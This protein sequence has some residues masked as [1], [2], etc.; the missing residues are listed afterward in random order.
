MPRL[1]WRLKRLFKAGIILAASL[2]CIIVFGAPSPTPLPSVLVDLQGA[3]TGPVVAGVD[4]FTLLTQTFVSFGG[5]SWAMRVSAVT[6]LAV[7]TMKVTKLDDLLWSKLRGLQAFLAPLLSLAGGVTVLA[8]QGTLSWQA[9]WLYL[10]AGAGAVALHELL[11]A[12]KSIPG[13]GSGYVMVIS[14]VERALG[15]NPKPNPSPSELAK[16]MAPAVPKG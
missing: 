4:F 11:D 8:A 16:G 2:S 10:G 5:M 6:L 7:A 15:G 14:A 9:V 12:T 1:P 13:L 3:V